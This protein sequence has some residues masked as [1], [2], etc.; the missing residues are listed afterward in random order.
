MN[1]TIE[2]IDVGSAFTVGAALFS[3]PF[4]LFGFL[5][6]L[7]PGLAGISVIG[8]L[9]GNGGNSYATG[10]VG[11]IMLYVFGIVANAMVGGIVTAI[12]AWLYNMAAGITGGLR[13]TLS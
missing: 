6:I 5:V 13:I 9:A 1:K 10:A 4:A 8:A 3:L 7:L 11:S 2:H 12:E